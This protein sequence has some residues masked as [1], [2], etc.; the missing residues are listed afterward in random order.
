MGE[1]NTPNWTTPALFQSM[2]RSA[3][4]P[5]KDTVHRSPPLPL[6]Y[7]GHP[8]AASRPVF[9]DTPPSAPALHT[10]TQ[11]CSL[12]GSS[13]DSPLPRSSPP[14]G[15]QI[16][17]GTAALSAPPKA[18][19]SPTW[20]SRS[21]RGSDMGQTL[22]HRT[23]LNELPARIAKGI[24]PRP[25]PGA[26]LWTEMLDQGADPTKRPQGEE[27]VTPKRSQGCPF[28]PSLCS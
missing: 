6:T 10:P 11:G 21:W 12:A 9:S 4:S 24:G 19:P 15:E 8:A 26:C 2:P 28:V 25:L 23:D 7:P 3:S 14:R 22:G 20:R 18:G 13:T 17:Q 27:A 5:S 16:L 1:K